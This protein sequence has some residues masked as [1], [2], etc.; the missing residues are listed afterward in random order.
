VAVTTERVGVGDVVI[1]AASTQGMKRIACWW[2][3]AM[4]EKSPV[5]CIDVGDEDL[6]YLWLNLYSGRLR[7]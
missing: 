2:R 7:L 3:S 6:T 5:Y 4:L 1:L